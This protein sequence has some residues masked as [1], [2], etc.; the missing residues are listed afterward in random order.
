MGIRF[1]SRRHRLPLWILL[2]AVGVLFV[3]SGGGCDAVVDGRDGP[4]DQIA[5][6]ST[7][8]G[9]FEIYLMGT[10]GGRPTNLTNRP[11]EGNYPAFSPDGDRIFFSSFVDDRYDIHTLEVGGSGIADVTDTSGWSEVG[12]SPDFSPGGEWM[13]YDARRENNVDIFL[14]STGG[15]APIRLTED[16]GSDRSPRFSS[17]GR[18]IYFHGDRTGEDAIFR[19]HL[20]G[21]P[22]HNLTAGMGAVG[23]PVPSP[24]GSDPVH[25]TDDEYQASWFDVSPNGTRV[26]YSAS[27]PDSGTHI[28]IV[29][30][31]GT[32]KRQLTAGG[33]FRDLIPIFRPLK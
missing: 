17:D 13:V 8:D 24:E 6:L 3:F 29:N 7:R 26:V 11:A 31:D 12:F 33:S 20:D 25:I 16:P 15:G 21:T 23:A 28:W 27:A 18:R 22:L 9:N 5:F 4:R 30:A 19:V 10:D 14:L 32:G 2:A 1:G